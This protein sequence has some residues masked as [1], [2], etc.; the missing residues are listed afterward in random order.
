MWN[1]LYVAQR[2]LRYATDIANARKGAHERVR[3]LEQ[4][5][6][7]TEEHINQLKDKDKEVFRAETDKKARIDI[8]LEPPYTGE[9]EDEDA[10]MVWVENEP[11]KGSIA[12]AEKSKRLAEANMDI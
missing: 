11:R 1:S 5:V 2:A 7:E 12:D 3:Q 6:A 4:A 10:Q 8:L 9:V